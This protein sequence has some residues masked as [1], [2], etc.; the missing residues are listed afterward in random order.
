ME[1]EQGKSLSEEM[2]YKL[3]AKGYKITGHEKC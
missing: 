1:N 2:T 3:R